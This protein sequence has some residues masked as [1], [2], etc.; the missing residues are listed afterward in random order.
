MLTL[1]VQRQHRL[2]RHVDAAK[3]VALQHDLAHLL[4]VLERVHGRLREEDLA[5]G[6][7]DLHLLVEG[8]V[9]QML[10]IIPLFDDAVFHLQQQSVNMPVVFPQHSSH[11]IADLQHRPRG[12]RLIAAH[13]ILHDDIARLL[14]GP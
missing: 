12:R 8:V 6:R 1:R 13:D 7:V 3:V 11:R 9:P 14:F 5:P 10:H 2:N 4:A